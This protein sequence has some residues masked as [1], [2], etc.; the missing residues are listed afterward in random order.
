ME[1]LTLGVATVCLQRHTSDIRYFHLAPKFLDMS[2]MTI[3]VLF[4]THLL[5]S[6]SFRFVDCP[7]GFIMWI[8]PRLASDIS[9][10]HA[11]SSCDISASPWELY[12]IFDFRTCFSNYSVHILYINAKNESK[13]LLFV[14]FIWTEN[15]YM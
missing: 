1:S 5:T 2:K 8:T 6:N 11:T 9:R 10:I 14:Y 7:E 3:N 12:M 15:S 4:R 13:L